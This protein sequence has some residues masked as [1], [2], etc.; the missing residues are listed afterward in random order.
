MATLDTDT[1]NPLRQFLCL[2]WCIWI[3][4]NQCCI[5]GAD[6]NPTLILMLFK[7]EWSSLIQSD[8]LRRT[9][10][11]RSQS[12]TS[13]PPLPSFTWG[14]GTTPWTGSIMIDGAW[15]SSSLFGGLGVADYHGGFFVW[16]S[17]LSQFQP[18]ALLRANYNHWK[19]L[20]LRLV[21]SNGPPWISG[22]TLLLLSMFCRKI[23]HPNPRPQRLLLISFFT[24]ELVVLSRSI[25]F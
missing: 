4:R 22:R 10:L 23:S 12:S 24:A 9:Q 2:I 15:T 5:S 19:R 3:L 25:D 6:P 18:K 21:I 8:P 20:S 11:P 16:P 7:Q 13:A 14:H 1:R 17:W